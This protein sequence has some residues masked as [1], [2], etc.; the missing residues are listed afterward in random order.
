[1]SSSACAKCRRGGAAEGDS[2]CLGCLA[3]ENCA[4]SLKGNWWS[5]S[6]RRLGEEILVQAAKQLRA[7]KSLDTSLQSFADS[8][9]A[10]LRKASAPAAGARRPPEPPHPP[11]SRAKLVEASAAPVAV[12]QQKVKPDRPARAPPV[13]PPSPVSEA[14]WDGEEERTR[15]ESE[16]EAPSPSSPPYKEEVSAHPSGERGGAGRRILPSIDSEAVALT[17]N[18]IEVHVRA[19]EEEQSIKRGIV[20]STNLVL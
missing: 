2:W 10:R 3:L 19:I 9:E 7:V 13:A 11:R 14:D 1:M 5:S 6:H 15:S 17:G 8:C 12:K 4:A 20:I 18:G 16:K